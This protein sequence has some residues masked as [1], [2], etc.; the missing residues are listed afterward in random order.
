M[1]PANILSL[2]NS[3][4]SDDVLQFPALDFSSNQELNIGS[5]HLARNSVFY[6]KTAWNPQ[7]VVP[8]KC[9]VIKVHLSCSGIILNLIK[10]RAVIL[11]KSKNTLPSIS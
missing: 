9:S 2:H 4:L 11:E 6:F 10:V 5:Q 8:G 3:C 1:V 7:L